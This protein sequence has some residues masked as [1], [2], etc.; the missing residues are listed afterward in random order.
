MTNNWKEMEFGDFATLQRGADLPVQHRRPGA[1]PVLASNGIVG[2]HE[3]PF[4]S[5]PG[6]VTGRSG[7]IGKPTFMDSPYW[8]LNTVL[9][10]SD[11]HGNNPLFVYFFFQFFDFRSYAT[12]TSVPTLNRNFVHSVPIKIPPKP[13]QEKITA[14]LW[15][16]KRAIEVEEKLVATS[17]ELKQ[18]AMRQLFTRGLHGESLKETDIGQMPDS[19]DVVPLGSLGR[20]GNGSTPLKRNLAYWT[21]GTIP[22][23]TSAKVYDVTITE[24]DHFVTSKALKEC[25]LP[26]IKPNSV[27]VAITGQGK[28]LGHTAV[29]SIETTIN[30]HL[31]Y[32]QFKDEEINPHFIR[33]FLDSRYEELRRIA[34][35]GGSTKGALTCGF[36]KTYLVPLPKRDEQD[37]ITNTLMM[38]EA[39]TSIHEQKRSTLQDLFKTLLQRLMTGQL[40]VDHLDI[41]TSEVEVIK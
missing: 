1:Y 13:E 24:A 26:R 14:V 8:P 31:A 33:L 18:S 6:V 22:W 35:G 39:K 37:A 29:T 10:V 23:L 41:D 21:D 17:R 3:A 30:Q 38:I 16:V 20:I 9:W 15:K 19:W 27:L 25:H 5:G 40:R 36:L 11:F 4:A 2:F 32:V 7:T 12:G 34:Q 28:T